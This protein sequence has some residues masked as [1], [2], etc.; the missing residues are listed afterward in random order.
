MSVHNRLKVLSK[1]SVIVL[2]MSFKRNCNSNNSSKMWYMSPVETVKHICICIMKIAI[3]S[4]RCMSCDLTTIKSRHLLQHNI[5]ICNQDYY[6]VNPI[7]VHCMPS[8]KCHAF[9]KKKQVNPFRGAYI[10]IVAQIVC[11]VT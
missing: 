3:R 1:V 2:G 10:Y 6:E 9:R 7:Y 5:I 8:L 11:V 4:S